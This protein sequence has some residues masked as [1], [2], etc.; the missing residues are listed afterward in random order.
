MTLPCWNCGKTMKRIGEDT[1]YFYYRC[2]ACL[3]ERMESKELIMEV[4]HG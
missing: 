4:E 1:F 3:K 2:P